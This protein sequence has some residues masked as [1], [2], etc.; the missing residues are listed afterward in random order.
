MK[1]ALPFAL[2]LATPALAQGDPAFDPRILT[3]AHQPGGVMQV[4]A[5]ATTTQVL[6]FPQG[7]HIASVV[8]SDASAFFV[9]VSG[10]G[11]SI[12]LR[13]ASASSRAV[14]SVR[15]DASTYDF[16]LV[17]SDAQLA[18][19]VIR[20]AQARPSALAAPA[21]PRSGAPQ[22]AYRLSGSSALLPSSIVD[23]GEKTYIQWRPDQSMPA[24]FTRGPTGTEQMVEGYVRGGVF[25]IDRVYSELIFRIDR[26][27]A[28]ARRVASRK[29]NG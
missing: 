15:A 13:A 19:A 5:S 24:T 27:M 16:E 8:I 2:V 14:L 28:R 18:P 6:V 20:I 22:F 17:A 9:T 1:L 21:R 23:D 4:P 11:D 7:E 29:G 25:T 10:T 26:D 12:A 3:L